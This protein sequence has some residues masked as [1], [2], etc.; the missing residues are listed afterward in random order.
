M[1]RHVPISSST[2][3]AAAF[4]IVAFTLAACQNAP[5]AP[6]PR[7]VVDSSYVAGEL[8]RIRNEPR[9]PADTVLVLTSPDSAAA[10]RDTQVGP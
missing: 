8:E 5:T 10:Q 7:R 4:G 2:L 3:K 6:H 9:H 1:L